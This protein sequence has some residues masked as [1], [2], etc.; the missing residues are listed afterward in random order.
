MS[1]CMNHYKHAYRDTPTCMC[2][3]IYVYIY[4]YIHIYI[5]IYTRI[6]IHIHIHI[7]GLLMGKLLVGV[8][9][10][11]EPPCGPGCP[12]TRRREAAPE[13]PSAADEWGR[14]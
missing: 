13:R 11:G 1:I 8:L 14:H 12:R 4:I 9:W 2:I 6:H 7:Q 10:A 5:Y 3:Y